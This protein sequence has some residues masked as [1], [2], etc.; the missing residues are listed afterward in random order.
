MVGRTIAIG[1]IHGC[2]KALNELLGAI[3][4][5][6]TDTV[7][8]LGDFIDRGPDSRGVLNKLIDLGE[9]CQ[10][11][12]LMGNLGF[13]VC[14]DTNCVRGGWLTA[15]EINTGQIWQA[16]NSGKLRDCRMKRLK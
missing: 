15:L 16:D 1:D 4:P 2:S 12:P 10:L 6:P 7:I 5:C 9:Q 3:A 14:I 8:A 13:L 11:V